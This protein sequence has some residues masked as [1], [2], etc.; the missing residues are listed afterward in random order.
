MAANSEDREE[1]EGEEWRFSLEDIERRH[2]ENAEPDDVDE[3]GGNVAGD[4]SP[5]DEVEAGDIDLENALF[6]LFGIA[7][8]VL[9]FAGFANVLP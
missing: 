4:L 6:V 5:D 1:N 8:A 9:M 2:A 3:G 7:L